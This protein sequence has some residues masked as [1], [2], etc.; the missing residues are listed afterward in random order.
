MRVVSLGCGE[1]VHAILSGGLWCA[2]GAAGCCNLSAGGADNYQQYELCL[3]YEGL[4]HD[5]PE[6]VMIESC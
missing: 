5:N 3:K 4:D 1:F 2:Q 6:S